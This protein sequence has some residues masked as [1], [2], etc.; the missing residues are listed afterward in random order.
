MPNTYGYDVDRSRALDTIRAMFDGPPAVI[1]TSRNYGV[2]RSEERLGAVISE[3]GGMPEGFVLSTKLD[4]DADTGRFDA[5]QA[6]QSLEESL[7][8]LTVDRVDVLHLHDP[9]H[10]RD[11]AEI[12]GKGGALEELFQMK[13]EGLADSVGLA[14]G[15]VDMMFPLLREF[16]FD[17]LINHNRFTLLNR[18]AEEM[19]DFAHANG[20]RVWNAA[21]YAG[22]VLAKGSA[23]AE[24][25]TYQVADEEALRPVKAVEE[26]CARFGIAPGAAA[27]QFS[28]KDPRVETTIVGVSKPERVAQTLE[29][30]N[31]DIPDEAWAALGE[32]S[33]ST[34]DP[35]AS[36]TYEHD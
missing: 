8:A 10:S 5:R 26:V 25:V 14:M 23:K 29:W 34:E 22:G 20:I 19:Y 2:G 1:D 17:A 24:R 28:M 36:R 7:T 31:A 32:L 30:A 13:S 35:E 16:P 11:L 6:R 3:R 12:A 27:L 33:Y 4:R 18:E 15:R 9:E 21:P